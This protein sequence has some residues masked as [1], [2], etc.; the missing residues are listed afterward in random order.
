MK[1]FQLG[2]ANLQNLQKSLFFAMTLHVFT[3]QKNM[4]F[5]KKVFLYTVIY[6]LVYTITS[7]I[8]AILYSPAFGP[9]GVCDNM[10]SYQLDDFS[11][12]L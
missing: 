12:H 2:H 1:P 10:S 9:R 4:E 8:Y 7:K 5:P 6:I 3:H 11:I